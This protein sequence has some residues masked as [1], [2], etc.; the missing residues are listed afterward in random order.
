MTNK[1]WNCDKLIV[2]I[3]VVGVAWVIWA[4]MTGKMD[5]QKVQATKQLE[6][7]SDEQ[8]LEKMQEPN[9][10]LTASKLYAE[11]KDNELRADSRYKGKIVEVT[12][13]IESIGREI[14]GHPYITLKID[15]YGW[16]SVQCVFPESE[17]GSL[18]QVSPGQSV[19]V[20]GEV[21][22][23][24]LGIVLITVPSFERVER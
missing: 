11:Y 3:L 17:I 19:K 20:V 8:M 6:K 14:L 15:D 18:I 10:Y 12:G 4:G 5:L 21:L 16:G 23:K 2:T 9:Y 1:S 22:G 7:S 24:T 13:V